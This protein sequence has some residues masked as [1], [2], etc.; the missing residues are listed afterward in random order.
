MKLI[1]T[2]R[3][4]LFGAI[5][6][7]VAASTAT[8]QSLVEDHDGSTRVTANRYLGTPLSEYDSRVSR[9]APA[10]ALN[11]Y[12]SQGGRI[13]AEDGTYLGRLNANRYDPESVANPYGRYG[14]RY[15]STSINNPYSAYGSRYSNQS[16]RN[17]YATEPPRVLYD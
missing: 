6:S 13:F 5:L 4:A 14:S 15:S 1:S 8:A 3:I 10:G 11:P 12:T 2:L 17:P 7:A 16:A 9:Y